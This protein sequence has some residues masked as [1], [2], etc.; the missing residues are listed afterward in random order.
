MAATDFSITI[1]TEQSQQEVFKAVN[2]VRSWWSGYHSEEI[3]GNTEHLGDEFSFSA[4]GGE[5]YSE[6]KLIEVI[7]YEKIVWVITY[8]KLNFLK[9]KDEW[10]GSKVIFEIST[11]DNK[12]QLKFTHQ[13][14]TAENECYESCAPGWTLYIQN[15]LVPLINGSVA[16]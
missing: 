6:Q 8:S 9:K 1:L 4:A 15:R 10:T 13:G 5:H 7:P 11:T 2:D 16:M 3:K 12:T 14:L